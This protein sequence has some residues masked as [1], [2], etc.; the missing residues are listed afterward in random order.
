MTRTIFLLALLL[1]PL[2]SASGQST[3]DAAQG[4]W[5]HTFEEKDPSYTVYLRFDGDILEVWR[6]SET[7][8]CEMFPS[9]V[10]WD[11]EDLSVGSQFQWSITTVAEDKIQV[12]FP[13]G[14]SVDY[15]RSRIDP[16]NLCG[17]RDI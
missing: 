9:I 15:Q 1:A 14:H 13:D 5:E 10:N 2:L 4:V 6:I 11:K 8:D 12:D 7:E 16:R 17:G 3:R